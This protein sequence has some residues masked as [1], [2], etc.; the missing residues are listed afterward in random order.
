MVNDSSYLNFIIDGSCNI[1]HEQMTNISY[2]TE[3]GALH[4][5][6]QNISAHTHDA[7]AMAIYLDIQF[8]MWTHDKLQRVYLF[9]MDTENKMQKMI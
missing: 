9:A 8:Q 2:N 6:S 1:N 5:S 7:Q 4:L 3:L